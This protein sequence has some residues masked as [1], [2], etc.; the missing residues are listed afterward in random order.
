MAGAFSGCG[1]M[2]LVCNGNHLRNERGIVA[3]LATWDCACGA[4]GS[5]R[6]LVAI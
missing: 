1:L 2:P 4:G 3:L 5:L 6:Y